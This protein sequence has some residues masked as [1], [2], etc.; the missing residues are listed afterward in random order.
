MSK[1]QKTI[2]AESQDDKDALNIIKEF[3]NNKKVDLSQISER[4]T[5]DVS[6][7]FSGIRE[8]DGQFTKFLTKY[9]DNYDKDAKARLNMK[10]YF[11]WAILVTLCLLLL[12]A[13]T[14][15]ILCACGV[16]L[17]TSAIIVAI[18]SIVELI[19]TIIS[20]PFIIAKHLF[21]KSADD[22]TNAMINSLLNH[23]IRFYGIINKKSAS[24]IN[25]EIKNKEDKQ[26]NFTNRL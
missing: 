1:S 25:K 10:R 4:K 5:Q 24:E 13:M 8:R 3:Q 22:K 9:I 23:D 15:I 18:S 6:D 14:S 12:G 17:G 11:F 20:L 26:R 2:E 16:I 21:P 19:S 7:D